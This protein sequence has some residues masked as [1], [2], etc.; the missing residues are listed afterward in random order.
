MIFDIWKRI[1]KLKHIMKMNMNYFNFFF[2]FKKEA[3]KPARQPGIM[4]YFLLSVVNVGNQQ[5]LPG[6]TKNQCQISF[7]FILFFLLCIFLINLIF[8]S[9]CLFSVQV[10]YLFMDQFAG[11]VGLRCVAHFYDDTVDSLSA[12]YLVTIETPL[13]NLH[14]WEKK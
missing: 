3:L 6:P 7:C 8:Q 14:G 11:A 13:Q 1:R 5:Q 9:F 2:F 10:Q 4:F 12:F